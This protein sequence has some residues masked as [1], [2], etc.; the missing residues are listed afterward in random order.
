M[1]GLQNVKTTH[2][3]NFSPQHGDFLGILSIS[4]SACLWFP[5]AMVFQIVWLNLICVLIWF[6]VRLQASH[7]RFIS[8]M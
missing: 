8:N 3:C 6:F 7:L 5:I 2:C 1:I 4:Q